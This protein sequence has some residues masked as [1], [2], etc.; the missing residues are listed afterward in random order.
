MEE[1]ANVD[2]VLVSVNHVER[3]D[4]VPAAADAVLVLAA[5]DAVLVPA[6]ADAAD[7]KKLFIYNK[8]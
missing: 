5:A 7:V 6:A 2:A 4:A 1:N 3:A 8:F